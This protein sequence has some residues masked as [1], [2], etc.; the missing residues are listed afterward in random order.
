MM[1]LNQGSGRTLKALTEE[2]SAFYH[3]NGW[4]HTRDV[5]SD[6]W[7]NRLRGAA[8]EIVDGA[9][10][11]TES[12]AAIELFDDHSSEHPSLLNVASPCDLH[13]TLWEFISSAPLID[14]VCDLL[15][16]PVSYRY[17]Q[18]R[19]MK[20]GQCDIWHQDMPFDAIDGEG[21]LAGIH[22]HET[23]PRQPR[24]QVISGSHRGEDFTQLDESGNFIGEL[25]EE[26]MARIDA[27]AAVDVF[28]TA[29]AIEFLDYRT[30]HQDFYAG[31]EE[32][33]VLMYA[34]YAT[35]G[36]VSIGESRY[37]SVPSRRKGMMLGA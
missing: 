23:A 36:A 27:R 31:E 19:F 14:R 22:L 11:M 18:F 29:G 26:E 7:L 28:P 2:Q 30:L 8:A 35:A 37:P 34:A 4:L 9:R 13:P 3:E 32:G 6:S 17:S 5:V 16:S 12:N 15:G 24:L 1:H 20:L 21:V 33:G 25:N 10:S